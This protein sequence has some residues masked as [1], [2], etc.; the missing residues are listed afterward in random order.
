MAGEPLVQDTA[1]EQTYTSYE[2]LEPLQPDPASYD[3]LLR[4]LDWKVQF[5]T[6]TVLRQVCKHQRELFF[7]L[8]EQLLPLLVALS[9]SIRSNL[10]KNALLLLTEMFLEPHPAHAQ[11]AEM[12]VPGLLQKTVCEKTFLK[13]QAAAALRNLC[14]EASS[15]VVLQQ[16]GSLCWHKSGVICDNAFL[17]LKIAYERAETGEVFR[18]AT[19]LLNSKRKKI[20]AGATSTLRSMQ[21]LPQFPALL[22]TLDPTLRAQ[23]DRA[24]LVRPGAAQAKDIRSFI[25]ERKKTLQEN[26]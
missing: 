2:A 5:S 6:L 22:A 4:S 26:N 25:E 24:L 17:Y 12:L 18:S 20:E 21:P 8:A 13:Q 9:D 16:L 10:S 14:R 3:G 7:Q 23:V 1:S 15:P 11:M 19:A